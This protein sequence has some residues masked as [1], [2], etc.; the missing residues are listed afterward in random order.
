MSSEL[1]GILFIAGMFVLPQV[2]G[3][4]AAGARRGPRAR[5]WEWPVVAAA[6]FA[7]GWYLLWS[8]QVGRET[9]QVHAPCGA[10]GLALMLGWVLLTPFH[11]IVGAALQW[12]VRRLAR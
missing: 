6:F 8:L 2:V 3:L 5:W 4:M 11:A 10:A 1:S 7:T 12:V 9:E